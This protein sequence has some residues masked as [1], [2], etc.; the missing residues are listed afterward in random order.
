[1]DFG[2]ETGDLPNTGSTPFLGDG[3][4][5]D[6]CDDFGTAHGIGVDEASFRRLL[7]AEAIQHRLIVSSESHVVGAPVL[8]P[9]FVPCC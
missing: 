7:F 5:V 6:L 8:S 1:M 2:D 4:A 9:S 3:D